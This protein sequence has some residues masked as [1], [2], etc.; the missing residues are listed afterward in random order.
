MNMQKRHFEALAAALAAS[1]LSGHILNTR[2]QWDKDVMAIASTLG[3]FNPL[4]R[5]QQFLKACD[6]DQ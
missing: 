6:Y 4:F 1:K 5:L 3:Q 2:A